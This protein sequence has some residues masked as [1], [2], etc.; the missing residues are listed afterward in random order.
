MVDS[1]R[2]LLHVFYCVLF[3]SHTLYY[4]NPSLTYLFS[5]ILGPI[6]ARSE[7]SHVVFHAQLPP[8]ITVIMDELAESLARQFSLTLK[9]EAEVDVGDGASYEN[10][11]NVTYDLVGRVVAE[12]SYSAHTLQ[13]NIERLLRPVRGFQFQSLGAN[14]FV[15][16]FNHQ[17]DRTHAMEGCPWLMDRHALL[18]SLIPD[19]ASP[20]MM[21]LNFMNIVV[22][23]HHIPMMYRKVDVVSRL[24]EKMGMVLEVIPPKGSTYQEYIRVRVQLQISE[25]FQRGTY[26]RLKGGARIWVSFTY[27]RMPIYCFLCGLVGHLEKKCQLR[28]ANGFVDPGRNFP[29]GEWLKAAEPNSN[30]SHTQPNLNPRV[31]IDQARGAG[32]FEAR[33]TGAENGIR[34]GETR[35]KENCPPLNEASGVIMGGSSSQVLSVEKTTGD[36]RMVVKPSLSKNRKKKASEMETEAEAYPR[37]RQVLGDLSQLVTIPVEAAT[38]PHRQP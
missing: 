5:H 26:M 37:K 35:S 2:S 17:L 21:I 14:K 15:L 27:E 32:I 25:P 34:I 10:P 24:C 22:R 36:T 12:K 6:F 8:S 18:L 30:Q 11:S 16:K 31:Q 13:L 38:Q 28:F 7:Q 3:Y 23:L 4:S 29:Y 9:E 19:E 1:H 20:E 33:R